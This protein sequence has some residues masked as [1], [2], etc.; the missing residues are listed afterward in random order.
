MPPPPYPPPSLASA[1]KFPRQRFVSDPLPTIDNKIKRKAATVFGLNCIKPEQLAAIQACLLEKD[2]VITLPTG[3]GK[4]LCFQLIPALTGGTVI[5][6][7]PLLALAADQICALRA[8]G[9][10]AEM[11][12]GRRRQG[13]QNDNWKIWKRFVR[14]ELHFLFMTPEFALSSFRRSF[15]PLPFLERPHIPVVAVDECHLIEEWASAG[16]FRASCRDIGTLRPLLGSVPVMALSATLTLVAKRN[17]HRLLNNTSPTPTHFRRPRIKSAPCHSPCLSTR[18]STTDDYESSKG[19][20]STA[21]SGLQRHRHRRVHNIQLQSDSQPRLP[22]VLALS[23]VY[24]T[25]TRIHAS[26]PDRV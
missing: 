14:G 25:P 11:F 8:R 2:T 13:M 24:A 20:A 7:C 26:Q 9:F 10:T 17:V 16:T 5:V 23:A 4:S 6:I 19:Q 3:F 15:A 22:S 12:Q 21:C 18:M 1:L